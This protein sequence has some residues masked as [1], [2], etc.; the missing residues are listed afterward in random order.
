MN[1]SLPISNMNPYLKVGPASAPVPALFSKDSNWKAKEMNPTTL[2]RNLE[3]VCRVN[4][5][6]SGDCR[7]LLVMKCILLPY[8]L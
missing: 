5:F 8:L 3:C 1:I 2:S 7:I 6:N 4:S